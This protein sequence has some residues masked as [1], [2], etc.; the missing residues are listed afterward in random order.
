MSALVT[1]KEAGRQ[2]VLSLRKRGAARRAESVIRDAE[3]GGLSW[4]IASF[5]ADLSATDLEEME[6]K[7]VSVCFFMFFSKATSRNQKPLAHRFLTFLLVNIL[8]LISEKS[9]WGDP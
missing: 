2:V 5:C 8:F 6:T 7:E 9:G 1:T 4:L 3:L